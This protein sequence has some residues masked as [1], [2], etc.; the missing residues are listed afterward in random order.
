MTQTI[1]IPANEHGALR[2]FALSM[3]D[4]TARALKDIPAEL[5]T[6]LGVPVDPDHVEIFPLSDL[7]GVGLAGYLADGHAVPDTELAPD[8]IKLDKLGGWV[9]IVYSRAFG[10]AATTLAP[11]PALTLIGTY[12]TP[13]TNWQATET[14]A[15]E[16]AKPYSAPPETVKKRPSDAAMSGRVATLVLILLA[17][18]T[19]VFIRIAG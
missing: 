14:I 11:D 1:D 7:E 18:F 15:S 8:R 12:G 4:E 5:M 10:G 16:A 13:G 6:A 2:V 3:T 17:L 19:Y 9:M